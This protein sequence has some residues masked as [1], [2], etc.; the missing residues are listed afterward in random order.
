MN[1]R[2]EQLRRTF[3]IALALL[4]G[5][6][7]AITAFTVGRLRTDSIAAGLEVSALHTRSFEDLIT[8][9]LHVI[10]LIAAHAV[11]GVFELTESGSAPAR[12]AAT[13]ARAPYLRSMSFVNADGRIVSSSNP[14]NL[15]LTIE[16]SR[17][18]PLVAG[19]QELLRVGLP[20]VG[21][22]FVSGRPAQGGPVDDAAPTF[23]PVTQT[24]RQGDRVLTVLFALNPDYFINLFSRK[25]GEPEGVV[26]VLRYDGVLLMSTD[27]KEH[28][29]DVHRGL[30]REMHLEDAESGA[31][32]R[33]LGDRPV[34]TTFRAS[35]AYPVAVVTDIDRD[36]ALRGWAI[37]TRSLL[38]VVGT[39][40]V[41]VVVLSFAYYRRQRQAI[42]ERIEA[43][44]LQRINATVF[45]S[46]SEAIVI[47]DSRAFII[48]LNAAFRNVAGY[49]DEELAGC[50]LP[51]LFDGA[52]Q[53]SFAEMV[54]RVD[55]QALP[56]A[57]LHRMTAEARLRC[58]DGQWI[59]TEIL[60]TP[61]FDSHGAVTGYNR[62]CRDISERRHME[63][64]VRKLAFFDPLTHVANRRLF[65]DRLK[66]AMS[67]C[68]RN[69]TFGALLFLDL[70]NF[71]PLN[72]TCGHD[73]G[74]LLLVGTANRLRACVRDSD[75]VGRFGG[76]EFVVVL[77][78][79][80]HERE[81]SLQ[82]AAVVAEKIRLR[83]ESP[84]LLSVE[85]GNRSGHCVEHRCSASIGLTL[86]SGEDTPESALRRA[87]EAMYQA[88]ESGGNTVRHFDPEAG[89]RRPCE[90]S[91]ALAET[92]DPE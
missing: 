63:E 79:L 21:R 66:T 33:S 77:S 49:S 41:A 51:D 57:A 6:M 19:G 76:D 71:K 58:K 3:I 5:G 74:D 45:D 60:S 15:D 28:P 29:G 13:L 4:I 23:I 62:I 67:A 47:A 83:L 69:G 80:S 65:L 22:D 8:Q 72:D 81:S 14:D 34:L 56:D 20:W 35:R 55:A 18:L 9:N 24:V 92:L 37:Q 54:E 48:S 32:E 30:L 26:R 17:F 46:S 11:S 70:D 85:Q 36:H 88:K 27:P 12:F 75:S 10:G 86:F 73:V 42:I 1:Q 82:Q 64:Q 87:D 39:V 44:R 43:E 7:A 90:H 40:L 84:F 31:M 16:T 78:T 50:R 25:V 53:A 61:Q 89:E 68:R 91:R 2:L 59:W 52:G 38:I